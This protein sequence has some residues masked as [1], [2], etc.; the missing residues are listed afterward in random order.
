MPFSPNFQDLTVWRVEG[1]PQ[2]E[3]EELANEDGEIR[4]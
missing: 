2:A 4:S 3:G 1:I